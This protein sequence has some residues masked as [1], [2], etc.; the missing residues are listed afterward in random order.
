MSLLAQLRVLEGVEPLRDISFKSLFTFIRVA[1]L[2]KSDILLAQPADWPSLDKAPDVLPPSIVLFLSRVVGVPDGCIPVL[3]D[4]FKDNV[5]NGDVVP[6]TGDMFDKHGHNLGL[7][8]RT[9]YPPFY[10]CQNADCTRGS[11][12]ALNKAEQRQA[13]LY[14]LSSGPVPVY[15]VHL[16]CER[17]R[18]N[19]HHNFWVKDGKRH[20]YNFTS[21]LPGIIQVGEHQFVEWVVVETWKTLMLVAW[22]SAANCARYYNLALTHGQQPPPGWVVG[23][24]LA[25]EHVWD[26]FLIHSL[27]SDAQRHHTTLVVP[28]T[29][30]QN[31]RFMDAI[32]SR[33]IY[34][35]LHGQPELRHYCE[36]CTRFYT[37]PEEPEKIYKTS[38]V[39][40]DGVTLGFPCCASPG[41][42]TDL[43]NNHSRFC[44]NHQSLDGDCAIIGC[45]QPVQPRSSVCHLAHHIAVEQTHRDRCQSRFQ[46]QERLQRARVAHLNDALP[47]DIPTSD[48]I[49][50]TEQDEEF[51]VAPLG[52]P[53]KVKIRAQFG[54]KRTHNEQI[55]VAPCG[56]IIA[57]ETFYNA[58]G[59]KSVADM[60]RQVYRDPMLMPNH[61]F[62]DNNCNL[63]KHVRGDPIFKDVGL[64]V[65][66]F[67]FKSKHSEQDTY[68]QENCNPAAYPELKDGEEKWYFNSSIAEQTNVWLGGYHAICRELL[69]DKYKFFLDEMIL[70]RNIQRRKALAQMGA[71]PQYW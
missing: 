16:Y 32:R 69:A 30:S 45:S 24:N 65:D 35:R 58:E 6:G 49:D 52:E 61:I 47:H 4:T 67:H 66:V 31:L 3:W 70:E 39:V 25:Y 68:C 13:V 21:T 19:Y 2:L 38:V 1:S 53:A 44:A 41:C 8:E 14:T 34:I 10:H 51:E 63:S 42:L 9:I 46:L 57:R 59:I 18:I 60:I 15:S 55:F 20:Y 56:I 48:L 27:L 43:A 22:A 12:L 71:Q 54:R 64:T 37:K 7:T 36:R 29:G 62:Y 28:H 26:G 17:C 40:I 50:T 5:W 11:R 23:Y 33:N